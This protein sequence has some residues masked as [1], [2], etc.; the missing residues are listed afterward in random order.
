[1]LDE[2]CCAEYYFPVPAK[3]ALGQRPLKMMLVDIF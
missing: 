3:Y 1:M 2:V